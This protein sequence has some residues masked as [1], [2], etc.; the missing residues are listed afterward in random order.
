MASL[1]GKIALITGAS[2]GLGAALA[3]ELGKQGAHI[4]A[5]ARTQGGLT[6]LDDKLRAATGKSATLIP[7]DLS[8]PDAGFAQLGQTLFERFKKLDTLVL[9]AAHISALSPLPHV[10]DKDWQKVMDVNVTANARLL[11]NLDPLLRAA[12]NPRVMFLTCGMTA[13]AHN[14]Y[15]GAYAASKKALEQLALSYAEETEKA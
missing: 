9:N 2:R 6:E 13:R 12:G 10:L 8:Q 4:I 5:L 7:F 11:R 15:W 3:L 1:D 14:A